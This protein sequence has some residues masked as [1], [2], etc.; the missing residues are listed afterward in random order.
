MPFPEMEDLLDEKVRQNTTLMNKA[1]K[2]FSKIDKNL[3][4]D[5][6]KNSYYDEEYIERE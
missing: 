4:K 3:F 2:E 6:F 1:K 5:S